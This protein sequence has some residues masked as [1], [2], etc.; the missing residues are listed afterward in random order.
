MT[1]QDECERA[2]YEYHRV[3]AHGLGVVVAK[4]SV[5]GIMAGVE[6]EVSED[7]T[8]GVELET[9]SEGVTG[10]IGTVVEAV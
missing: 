3:P 10:V 1:A 2:R 4:A 6:V 7:V 5:G 9:V 8:A